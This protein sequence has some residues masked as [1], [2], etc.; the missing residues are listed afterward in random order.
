MKDILTNLFNNMGVVEGALETA[1]QYASAAIARQLV[2]NNAIDAAKWVRGQYPA[3]FGALGGSS[4]TEAKGFPATVPT[5]S[6]QLPIATEPAEPV[7]V[8]PVAPVIAA[9]IAAVAA[10][11]RE[12]LCPTPTGEPFPLHE[13][14]RKA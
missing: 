8:A 12:A 13:D 3:L 6:T 9:P 7:V 5:T 4:I 14:D 10:G 2:S 11:T 1:L